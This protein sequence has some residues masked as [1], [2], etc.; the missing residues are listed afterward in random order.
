M[1]FDH[2]TI[3]LLETGDLDIY[4]KLIDTNRKRLED[5][6]AGTVSKTLTYED[7][8]NFVADRTKMAE[9]KKYYP[10]IIVDN[11]ANEIAGY[12]DIKNIDWRIP[13][14][15][16]GY[17]VDEKYAGTGMA[18]KAFSLFLDYCNTEMGFLKLFLRTHEGNTPA[19]KLVEKSG[20]QIE[21]TIRKDHR[22]TSG[23]IIDLL[24][25][26]KIF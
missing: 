14:A 12:I 20:F 1:N 26:G 2:Y 10:F 13:K 17:Y 25:Y 22:T 6:F 8:R 7:T 21:G 19:R 24:Y 4:W 11:K 16:L 23:E 5:F 3:R 9:E 18:S 15:E